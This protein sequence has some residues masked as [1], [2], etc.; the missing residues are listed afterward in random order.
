VS[1]VSAVVLAVAGMVAV[2][3]TGFQPS[4]DPV[5]AGALAGASPLAV[6]QT[7]I[8]SNPPASRRPRRLAVVYFVL[9][10]KQGADLLATHGALVRDSVFLEGG[11]PA[12]FPEVHYLVAG[13]REEES[14]AIQRF[15]VYVELASQ[16]RIDLQ[17]IDLRPGRRPDANAASP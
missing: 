5:R 10:E 16:Q 14:L 4:A 3:H 2:T 13:T 1:L 9:T 17:V 12:R 7:T 15:N 6:A 8:R 11:D